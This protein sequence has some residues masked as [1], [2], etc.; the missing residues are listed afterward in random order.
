[1]TWNSTVFQISTMVGPAVGGLLLS[2]SAS[3]GVPVA[4]ACVVLFRLLGL[5]GT[6]LVRTHRPDRKQSSI[7]LE[8]LVAGIRFVWS[9]KPILA[10]ISLD[11]FAV[12][13]GGAT[14]VL[15]AFADQVL[16]FPDEQDR[17]RRRL[18]ALGGGR[19]GNLSW[20]SCWPICRRSAVP[21]GPCSGPSPG[22]AR[23]PS[24]WDCRSI[25]GL[26]WQPCS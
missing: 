5:A 25:S 26:R 17:G 1:M 20:P 3:Q 23:R 16:H 15:P 18:L 21:D 13:L 24:A 22:S 9:Q 19:R 14:F 6:L 7:S 4:L 10:T 11:L 12:L 2:T 8:T